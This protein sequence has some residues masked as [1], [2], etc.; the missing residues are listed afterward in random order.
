ML[1]E[2]IKKHIKKTSKTFLNTII[3]HKI[4][5]FCIS[6]SKN[7]LFFMYFINN[8]IFYISH[9]ENIVFSEVV[10]DEIIK[11]GFENDEFEFYPINMQSS[12]FKQDYELDTFRFIRL[13][14]ANNLNAIASEIYAYIEAFERKILDYKAFYKMKLKNVICNVDFVDKNGILALNEDMKWEIENAIK[15]SIVE[16]AQENI[17]DSK[18]HI[19]EILFKDGIYDIENIE[20]NLLGK[21]AIKHYY[22]RLNLADNVEKTLSILLNQMR[23]LVSYF[24]DN[25]LLNSNSSGKIFANSQI[26]LRKIALIGSP[27]FHYLN[28]DLKIIFDSD[29]IIVHNLQKTPIILRNLKSTMK[30]NVMEST[31]EFNETIYIKDNISLKNSAILDGLERNL[32]SKISHKLELIYSVN[33]DDKRFVGTASTKISH[34]FL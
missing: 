31:T 21:D 26:I 22:N 15:A 19:F 24:C 18:R 10:I 29:N 4:P 1:Y 12:F 20:Q 27:H 33:G 2:K 34:I 23:F 9:D 16:I 32:S 3:P 7:P 30:L 11:V 13:I 25:I 6:D 14:I 8:D 17:L 5:E 28:N